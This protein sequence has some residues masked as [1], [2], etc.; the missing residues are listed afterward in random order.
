MVNKASGKDLLDISLEKVEDSDYEDFYM[1]SED[2][3]DM[4]RNIQDNI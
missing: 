1:E 4:R 3:N 2:D